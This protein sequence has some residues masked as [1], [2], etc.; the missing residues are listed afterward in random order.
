MIY[1]VKTAEDTQESN[2]IWQTIG[3]IVSLVNSTYSVL[4]E[5]DV[6]VEGDLNV[7]GNFVANKQYVGGVDF[8]V[9]GEAG[10]ALRR[11]VLIPYQTSDGAWRLKGN[12]NTIHTSGV[13]G[14]III[15]GI[16][17]KDAFDQTV[18]ATIRASGASVRAWATLNTNRI[19]VKFSTATTITQ[20]SFDVELN[21]K[22]DW[23]D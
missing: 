1:C 13:N 5:G 12:I 19:E 9:T 14:D 21:S 7:T 8:T 20:I 10:F 23:A 3:N 22:P 17:Y 2:S 18:A 15:S 16:T 11:A 6:T 4:F